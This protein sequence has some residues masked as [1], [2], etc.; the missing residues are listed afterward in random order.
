[1]SDLSDEF[2]AQL[3]LATPIVATVIGSVIGLVFII[4]MGRFIVSR[5]RGTVK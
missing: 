1:M 4:A 2:I 3:A 5:V